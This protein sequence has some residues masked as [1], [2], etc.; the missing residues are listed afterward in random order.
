MRWI[1]NC[2]S[3]LNVCPK[4]E[5]LI[6]SR[7]LK[8]GYTPVG[9]SGAEFWWLNI[10][11]TL[12][13]SMQQAAERAVA[14][15]LADLDA[16]L[17]FSDYGSA[18]SDQR[19]DYVQGALICLDPRTGYVKAMVGGRDIFV[20]YYNRATQARRQ[21]GSGFKPFVYLAAFESGA[22]S[23]VSLFNDSWRT[24]RVNDE[25]WSP[26]NFADKYLGLTTAANAL[27][28]SANATS[29]QVAMDIG[30]ERIVDLAQR[31][32]IQSRLRPYPSICPG[33]AGRSLCSYGCCLWRDCQLRFSA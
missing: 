2:N 20:S 1:R 31:L 27:V 28:K 25:D 26:R 12:D 29:V 6:L 32:G 5:R 15:G 10:Y 3:F 24:Y 13:L 14:R 33:R 16:R 21:P 4:I 8:R 22:F 9:C 11:T 18:S 30:P 17:G 19:A 7:R 23:P